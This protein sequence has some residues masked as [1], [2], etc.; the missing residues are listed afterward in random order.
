MLTS[1]KSTDSNS[2]SLSKGDIIYITDVKYKMDDQ[3]GIT[4]SSGRTILC[5]S[6]G[7]QGTANSNFL[8]FVEEEN[9]SKKMDRN[10]KELL[11]VIRNLMNSFLFTLS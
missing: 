3:K 4:E 8:E 5:Y 6:K 11:E 2:L 7:K 10:Y 1:S 9:V